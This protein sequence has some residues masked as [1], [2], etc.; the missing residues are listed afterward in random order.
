MVE[1]AA[2]RVKAGILADMGRLPTTPGMTFPHYCTVEEYLALSEA[3]DEKIEYLGSFAMP[4][5]GMAVA[6]AGASE[7]HKIITTNVVGGL[8]SRLQGTGCRAYGPDAKVAV[9]GFPSYVH[10][11]AMVICGPTQLDERDATGHTATNPRLIVEV[12]SPSSER[13]DRGEKF[14][15]YMA[16]ESLQEYVLAA[17]DEMRVDVVYRQPDGTWLMTP[18]VGPDAVVQLRS[19]NVALPMA[20]IYRDVLLPVG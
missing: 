1:N 7:N 3:T 16:A 18:Y 10:P 4:H 5:G 9:R 14:T 20:E 2:G 8:W 11:D 6:M 15:R 12:L 19:I 13:Y 17:Q